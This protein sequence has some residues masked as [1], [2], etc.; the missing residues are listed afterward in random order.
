MVLALVLVAMLAAV[1]FGMALTTVAIIGLMLFAVVFAVNSG[2]FVF[3]CALCK[4]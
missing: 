3:N 2:A 1:Y 4:G